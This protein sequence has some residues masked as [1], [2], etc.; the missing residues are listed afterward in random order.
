MR[1]VVR[2]HIQAVR[3]GTV[4]GPGEVAD[5]RSTSPTGGSGADGQSNPQI[6]EHLT[7]EIGDPSPFGDNRRLLGGL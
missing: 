3:A 4:Y 6:D 1:V 7:K 5:I 2:P